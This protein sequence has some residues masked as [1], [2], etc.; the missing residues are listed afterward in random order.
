MMKVLDAPITKDDHPEG[1]SVQSYSIPDNPDN[2][3]LWSAIRGEY[4]IDIGSWDGI[5]RC[6]I[7]R[8]GH[9]NEPIDDVVYRSLEKAISWGRE[10]VR[11]LR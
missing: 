11:R 2:K 6:R 3:K 10:W 7:I 1:W 8:N 9:W 4:I 5:Y